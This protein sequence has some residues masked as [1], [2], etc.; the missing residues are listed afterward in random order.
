MKTESRYH[1]LT[2]ADIGISTTRLQK[3][4]GIMKVRGQAAISQN[5]KQPTQ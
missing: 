5:V 4:G 2:M 3:Y 1:R